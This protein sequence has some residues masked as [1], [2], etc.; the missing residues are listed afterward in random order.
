[1]NAKIDLAS[2]FIASLAQRDV[3]GALALAQPDSRVHILPLNVQGLLSR[4]GRA[5]FDELLGAFPDL[6][7]RA[8]RV[9][10]GNDGTVVAEITIDGTQAGAFLGVI[11]Q[12]KHVDLDAAWLVRVRDGAIEELKMFWC[13]NQLYR[14]L[15]VRRLDRITITA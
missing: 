12:E 15:A 6:H 2:S 7:L 1:M 8:R 5:F 3:S 11:N 13:Q 9:F 4:E 14:R 10:A